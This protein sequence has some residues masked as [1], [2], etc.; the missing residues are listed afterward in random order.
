MG[1]IN[2]GG[3]VN[4]VKVF[5]NS[6]LDKNTKGEYDQKWARQMATL[7]EDQAERLRAFYGSVNSKNSRIERLEQERKVKAVKKV[8]F[9]AGTSPNPIND[10]TT[11]FTAF[12]RKEAQDLFKNYTQYTG[13]DFLKDL[14][15][16]D[17][18]NQ[19]ITLEQCVKFI[20]D[21]KAGVRY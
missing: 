3:F 4:L 9:E 8:S 14:I 13:P 20:K 10:V 15:A 7:F 19:N 16:D 2:R 11:D 6:A 21:F 5:T 17:R 18:I 1:A 12:E